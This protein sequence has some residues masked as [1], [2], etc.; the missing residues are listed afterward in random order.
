MEQHIE[1]VEEFNAR[2]EAS[3]NGDEQPELPIETESAGDDEKAEQDP[4]VIFAQ[5]KRKFMRRKLCDA[6]LMNQC[7]WSLGKAKSKRNLL[8]FFSEICLEADWIRVNAKGT[9]LKKAKL[10]Y[11]TKDHNAEET[12]ELILQ[13][14]E[15]R[16]DPR[17]GEWT[18]PLESYA[19]IAT[20]P[21]D[22]ESMG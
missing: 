18:T 2:M 7:G 20:K 22:F 16:S 11:V 6:L 13:Y 14:M 17:I 1:T 12:G 21:E 19:G 5:A 15:M 9:A 4:S 8:K 10:P 3:I